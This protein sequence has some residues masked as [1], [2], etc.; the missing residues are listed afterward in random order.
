MEITLEKGARP[1]RSS[2]RPL[3]P[4]QKTNL[5]AQLDS[6]LDQ[7]IIEPCNSP[8]A[9]ALVPVKKKDGRTCWVVDYR[10]LNKSKNRDSYPLNSIQENLVALKGSQVFST[11]D[12][13]GAYHAI[14]IQPSS[15][16]LTAFITPFSTFCYVRM[17][18]GL[19]NA[20]AVYSRLIEQALDDLPRDYRSAYLDDI[21]AYS[22]SNWDHF[23]HLKSIVEAHAKAGIK[24]QPCK[25]TLLPKKSNI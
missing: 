4:D 2:L 21:L 1:V 20:G 23:Q 25:T 12:A 7:G 3:N 10:N 17:P 22:K 16:D 11:I 13:A 8:W 9:S 5:R 14:E 15:R 6:W 24:I 18:F 19:T